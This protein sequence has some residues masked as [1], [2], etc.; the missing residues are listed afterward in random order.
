MIRVLT[1]VEEYGVI[2]TKTLAE[3]LDLAPTSIDTYFHRAA[4]VLGTHNRYDTVRKARRLGLLDAD[5]EEE[6]K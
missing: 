5:S 3:K 1:V 4:E 6:Q 2:D